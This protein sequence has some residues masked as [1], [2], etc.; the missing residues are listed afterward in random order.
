MEKAEIWDEFISAHGKVGD[1][2]ADPRES[3]SRAGAGAGMALLGPPWARKTLP[4]TAD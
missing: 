4:G 1:S 3:Q 2:G